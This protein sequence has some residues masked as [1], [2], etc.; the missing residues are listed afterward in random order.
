M[1]GQ[2]GGIVRGQAIQ[3]LTASQLQPSSGEVEGV[4]RKV[5]AGVVQMQGSGHP[6]I[7]LQFQTAVIEQ[8]PAGNGHG[9][10][11]GSLWGHAQAGVVLHLRRSCRTHRA[12]GN[13]GVAAKQR[14]GAVVQLKAAAERQ[15]ATRGLQRGV[16]LQGGG[17]GDRQAGELGGNADAVAGV[18]SAQAGIVS[19]A[20][21]IV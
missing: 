10:G 9:A 12:P 2:R 11:C 17:S 8:Q 20:A 13:R 5:E 19:G 18:V 16:V 7:R 1:Q 6:Q 21:G 15:C 4:V 3:R 14:E